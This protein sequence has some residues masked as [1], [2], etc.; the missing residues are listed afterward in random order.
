[1]FLESRLA[2]KNS[3][4]RELE[5]KKQELR[6]AQLQIKEMEYDRETVLEFKQQAKVC[7]VY[8]F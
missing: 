1:M 5:M 3:I 6:K 4:D 2:E 8:F 7:M